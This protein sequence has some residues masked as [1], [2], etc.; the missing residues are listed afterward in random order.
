MDVPFNKP[1]ILGNEIEHIKIAIKNN[2]LC[3]DGPYT[4]KCQD[5]IEKKFGSKKTFLT[6]S[7]TK[8]LEMAYILSDLKH[9]N[10]VIMPSYAFASPAS[11]LMVH[12]AKPVLVDIKEDTLNIDESKIEKAISKKTKAILVVHYAGVSCDMDKIINIAKKHNLMVIEDA[13]QGVCSKYKGKYL[14]TIGDFGCY[15]FHETKNIICGEGGAI[16]VNNLNLIERAEIVWEK[17]TNRKKFLRGEIDKYSWVDIGSSYV[18]SDILAAFLYPQLSNMEK[19]LEKRKNIYNHYYENLKDLEN[20]DILRLPIIP[21]E[22]ESN[23]H[24]F[25]VLLSSPEKADIVKKELKNKGISA[26]SHFVPLHISEMGKK[27][28]Y[29]KGDFPVAESASSRLLRLPFYYDLTKK[30]QDYVINNLRRVL[31]K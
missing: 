11:A 26:T 9:K 5:L 18:I 31:L 12:G 13:A 8:G 14:G 29:K 1:L 21:K 7:C 23:Y 17:G 4:K 2:K 28:G 30:E 16:N 25:Y 20:K 15:S 24:M 19:I 27:L 6:T 3:G 10:E 22:C